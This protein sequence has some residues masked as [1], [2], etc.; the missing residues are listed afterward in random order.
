M[1]SDTLFPISANH[2]R[3]VSVCAA[4]FHDGCDGSASYVALLCGLWDLRVSGPPDQGWPGY[5]DLLRCKTRQSVS[6]YR[7]QLYMLPCIRDDYTQGVPVESYWG[8]RVV[9]QYHATESAKTSVVCSCRNTNQRMHVWR[10][11][12]PMLQDLNCVNISLCN[13]IPAL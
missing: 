5:A 4:Q 7:W 6:E 10:R 9:P 1:G 3:R 2:A 12:F 11:Y 13:N 8:C